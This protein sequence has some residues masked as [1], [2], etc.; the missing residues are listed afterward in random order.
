MKSMSLPELGEQAASFD[1]AVGQT[2]GIDL[3]CSSLDW[4][5]PAHGAFGAER[6]PWLFQG[7]STYVAFMKGL[8]GDGF[9]Y[10]VP[11]EGMWLLGSPFA[12][13]DEARFLTEVGQLFLAHDD[14]DVALLA[15]MDQSQRWVQSL[16]RRLGQDFRIYGG[17]Q[18]IRVGARLD[19]GL[20]GFMSD[21]TRYFRRNLRR[22]IVRCDREGIQFSRISLTSLE[23]AE[24]YFDRIM[25]VEASSWKGL[26]ESGVNA[27]E[28]REFYRLM[29][30]RLV[31]RGAA[32]LIMAHR[33]GEDL[34]FIFGAVSGKSYRGLQFS[35]KHRLN[36]LGLG[37][38]LQYQA[39]KDL[40]EE[41]IS[42]YDLGTDIEYKRRWG[43][44]YL[45]T[46]MFTMARF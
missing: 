13:W 17:P 12:F 44:P 38:V 45:T 4:G 46:S 11:L 16:L 14:W 36:R 31:R 21:R 39:I 25:N 29:M 8:H 41:G 34:G 1:K 3:F 24:D 5:L 15:G 27:G 32:R 28:M 33:D 19:D 26:S 40:T 35:F 6:E 9:R 23:E 2:S 7:E 20:E 42:L 30:P 43:E 37:N 18:T 10:L 22:D